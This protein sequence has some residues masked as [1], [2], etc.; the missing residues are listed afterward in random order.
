[1][2]GTR[3]GLHACS[4]GAARMLPAGARAERLS[5]GGHNNGKTS[6]ERL[7]LQA[8]GARAGALSLR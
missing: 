4:R 7:A 8:A 2:P 1:M 5:G 6:S 3:V